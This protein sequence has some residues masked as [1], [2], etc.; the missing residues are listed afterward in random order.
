MLGDV[1]GTKEFVEHM[2]RTPRMRRR[3]LERRPAAVLFAAAG[4]DLAGVVEQPL[5][6]VFPDRI[7]T[8]QP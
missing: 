5:R 2:V 6:A 4:P 8:V 3:I 7:W 1:S